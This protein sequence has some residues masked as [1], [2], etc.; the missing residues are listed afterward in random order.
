MAPTGS[1]RP[2]ASAVAR[3]SSRWSL[4]ALLAAL[5]SDRGAAQHPGNRSSCW[6][7]I[8]SGLSLIWRRGVHHPNR[9]NAVASAWYQ[10]KRR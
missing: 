9:T 3:S 5:G 2:A 4:I 1:Y 10:P 7:V 6:R 8:P